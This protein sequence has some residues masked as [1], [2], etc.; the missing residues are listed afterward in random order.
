MKKLLSIIL[1]LLM[2]VSLIHVALLEETAEPVAPVEKE[3]A[4]G[5][6]GEK[7]A[8]VE[9]EAETASSE[10]VQQTEESSAAD[11]SAQSNSS[12]ASSA[13]ME[14]VAEDVEVESECICTEELRC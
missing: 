4:A 1:A 12:K 14:E 6:L 2:T 7:S 10:P 5:S 8:A 13:Q 11:S 9:S 3:T